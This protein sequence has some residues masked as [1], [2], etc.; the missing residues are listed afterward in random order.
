MEQL[1]YKPD[2]LNA[3]VFAAI[4]RQVP[5]EEK[6][7]WVWP[8]DSSAYIARLCRH[9]YAT[10]RPELIRRASFCQVYHLALHGFFQ[11]A[12]DLLHLGNLTEIAETCG[13][14]RTQILNNRCVAQ[15]G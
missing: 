8:A 14:V 15:M 9:V 11:Q 7:S 12:R 6:D 1:Y 13:D 10:N 5:Q 4:Q 2:M 3:A